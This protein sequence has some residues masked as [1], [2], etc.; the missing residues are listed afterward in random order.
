MQTTNTPR[1]FIMGAYLPHG[2]AF[3]AYHLGRI[4][5]LDF[6]FEA[7]AVRL[8]AEARD[9]GLFQYDPVLPSVTLAAMETT[10]RDEDVLI[11]N[12]S[13]SKYMFG[14]RLPGRKIC[15]V[16]GFTTFTI[17]DCRFQRYVAV[18]GFIAR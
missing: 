10:I 14:L 13:F 12:P 18:S 15:Y 16:Q 7:I 8:R 9:T 11:V 2:G 17:L 1:A 5:Q 3:M 4:L 6:N